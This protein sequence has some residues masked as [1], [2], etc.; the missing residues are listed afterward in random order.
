[1]SL[2]PNKPNLADEK[3]KTERR[4]ICSECSYFK[5]DLGLCGE[6]LCVVVL[7]T[8]LAESKCPVDKW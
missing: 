5:K 1:M 6:C 3:L 8:A 2:L 7:K 4:K